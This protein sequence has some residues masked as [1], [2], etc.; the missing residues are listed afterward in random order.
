MIERRGVP[1]FF[2]VTGFALGAEYALVRVVFFVTGSAIGLELVFVEVARMAALTFDGCML[3]GQ[4]VFGVPI[5]AER[6]LFPIRFSVTSDAFLPKVAFVIIV[7][8]MAGQ[9]F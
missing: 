4:R 9:A 5:M 3:V 6:N 8:F 7:F 2:A 1:A